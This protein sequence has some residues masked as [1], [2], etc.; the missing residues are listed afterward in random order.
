MLNKL[1]LMKEQSPRSNEDTLLRISKTAEQM[2]NLQAYVDL[3]QPVEKSKKVNTGKPSG[4]DVRA[5]CKRL[6]TRDTQET[7]FKCSVSHLKTMK[8]CSQKPTGRPQAKS[9]V[10]RFREAKTFI[11]LSEEIQKAIIWCRSRKLKAQASYLGNKLLKSNRLKHVEAQGYSL[12]KKL[13]CM[14]TSLCNC[15][16]RCSNISTSKHHLRQRRW[17]DKFLPRQRKPQRKLQSTL[18]KET[19]QSPQGTLQKAKDTSAQWRLSGETGQRTDLCLNS[20][21]LL[22]T[23]LS[24]PSVE[25]KQKLFHGNLRGASEKETD[26]WR[27]MQV[28]KHRVSRVVKDTDD[29]DDIFAVMGV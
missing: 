1:F 22:S 15:L 6:K 5:F 3:G 8:H 18:L 20:R 21:P 26:W 2:I 27:K 16:L 25:A 4:L 10:L 12:P 24:N 23:R 11:Q 19:Q 9:F 28:N 14:K 7:S 17:Q 29:I 13:E